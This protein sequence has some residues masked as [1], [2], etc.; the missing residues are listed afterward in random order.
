MVSE[1]FW[2]VFPHLSRGVFVCVCGLFPLHI[3]CLKK[4]WVTVK[5]ILFV[6][7][8]RCMTVG[9]RLWMDEC[10]QK[11]V[12]HLSDNN[13]VSGQ[14]DGWCKCT[15]RTL[16]TDQPCCWQWKQPGSTQLW[17]S[18]VL[19]SNQDTFLGKHAELLGAEKDEGLLEFGA[20]QFSLT[21]SGLKQKMEAALVEEKLKK[22]PLHPLYRLWKE[23][24]NVRLKKLP[25]A[26]VQALQKPSVSACPGGERRDRLT[27]R[28]DSFH[29]H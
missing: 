8:F 17:T 6:L 3:R 27:G 7:V 22:Q 12:R 19:P 24:R 5:S 28:V 26:C 4:A 11:E 14:N 10:T 29:A 16:K 23:V 21:L 25:E 13:S 20:K 9:S 15:I 2:A 1:E 18:F